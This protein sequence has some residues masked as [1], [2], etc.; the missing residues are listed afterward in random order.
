MTTTLPFA[1]SGPINLLAKAG[2]GSI[3]VETRDDL[4][5]ARVQLTARQP[6]S[7][8]IERIT[9]EMNG[10]T[11]TITTPKPS[12]LIDLPMFL[13]R[14]R[15]DAVEIVVTVPTGT[16]MKIMSFS[17]DIT[18]HGRSGGVDI[19]AGS[20]RVELDEV[21]GDVRLRLGRGT[22]AIGRVRGSI[23]VKSGAGD[24]SVGDV[25]GTLTSTTGNGRLKVGA[26]RG[27]VRA[28]SGSGPAS[29]GAVYGNVDLAS[30]NGRLEIGIPSGQSARLDVTTGAG[31]VDSEFTVGAQPPRDRLRKSITV[32][33]RTGSGDIRLFRAV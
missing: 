16:A 22:G 17:S 6:D 28:R 10:P 32:R 29:L 13:G 11:L 24:V 31:T 25:S 18:V 30:G 5:E 2:Q 1:L 8:I 26:V 7:D 4:T 9:V 15:R 27:A 21:D 14:S 3:T 12:S 33:A 19:S 23:D 20:A